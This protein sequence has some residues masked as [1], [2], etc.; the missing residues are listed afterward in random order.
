MENDFSNRLNVTIGAI[1]SVYHRDDPAHLFQALWS[2]CRNQSVPLDEIVGVIEGD[3][4]TELSEVVQ[5]FNE[6]RWIRIPKVLSNQGFGLPEALNVALANLTSDIVLKVDTDDINA[7][8]RIQITKE[9][10]EKYPEIGLFGGQIEEWDSI[11][12]KSFGIRSVPLKH[13]DIL[14]FALKRNPF[15]GPSVAFRRKQALNLGGFP[16]VAANEDFAFWCTMLH[17]GL[18][19]T[20]SDCV[21]VYMRGGEALV[22]RRSNRRTLLGELQTLRFIY[23]LGFWN[24]RTYLIHRIAKTIIRNL[25]L[26]TNRYIYSL[27]RTAKPTQ[28][29]SE[30]AAAVF[31][32][33]TFSHE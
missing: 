13:V 4:S 10:F 23:E 28:Q 8:N 16:F 11:F 5:E 21:L 22:K 15:N 9:T 30:Y 26:A 14:N 27:L 12:S 32:W 1:L 31:A 29:P 20:N 2:L 24:Q 6:I 18:E 17:H 33:N 3:I 25:P 7:Q 19:S